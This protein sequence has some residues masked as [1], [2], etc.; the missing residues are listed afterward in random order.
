MEQLKKEIKP[1]EL[2][3]I[4]KDLTQFLCLKF[5][6][7]NFE[8][9]QQ[10]EDPSWEKKLSNWDAIK[11]ILTFKETPVFSVPL[12]IGPIDK[13]P[14]T[15]ILPKDSSKN[16]RFL[17]A[18][19][20]M[21]CQLDPDILHPCYPYDESV[22]IQLAFATHYGMFMGRSKIA[23]SC[24]LYPLL[25]SKH[26]FNMVSS[27]ETNPLDFYY[28]LPLPKEYW[29]RKF[30]AKEIPFDPKTD[31][32]RTLAFFDYLLE[33]AKREGKRPERVTY[34]P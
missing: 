31:A 18:A 28:E 34:A 33:I 12:Y 9:E 19:A 20:Y 8:L 29:G 15:V 26:P 27:Q 10:I 11:Q 6:Y 24:E 5:E 30:V 4:K 1:E 25:P 23:D 21:P 3:Q 14:I 17:K 32:K 2:A 7:T 13:R 16:Y 22:M